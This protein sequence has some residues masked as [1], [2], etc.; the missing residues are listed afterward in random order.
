M[1]SRALYSGFWPRAFNFATAVMGGITMLLTGTVQWA[2]RAAPKVE[3]MKSH[4]NSIAFVSNP[5]PSSTPSP[6]GD[7]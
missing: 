6:H 1:E 3:G 5:T 4:G 7:W 2:C